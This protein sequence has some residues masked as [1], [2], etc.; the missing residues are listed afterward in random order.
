MEDKAHWTKRKKNEEDRATKF[1]DELFSNSLILY[2]L[3]QC[4]NHPNNIPEN[5]SQPSVIFFS[6]FY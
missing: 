2:A 3:S 5:W 1:E 6:K 4:L